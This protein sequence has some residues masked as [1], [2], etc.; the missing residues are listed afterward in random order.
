MND[1]LRGFIGYLGIVLMIAIFIMACDICI[2]S[3]DVHT[4]GVNS[5]SEHTFEI[6]TSSQYHHIPPSNKSLWTC[7]DH[8]MNHSLHNPSWGMVVI[9]SNRLFRGENHVVNYQINYSDN[10]LLI[11]DGL[12]ENDYIISGWE[13]DSCT[14]DYYHFYIDSE[15]PTRYYNR[16]NQ[17]HIRPN[18][19]EVYRDWILTR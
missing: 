6:T 17:F 7:F 18:A 3:A 1:R 9:S 16:R 2:A 10:T 11:H 13:Y 15:R 19:E 4:T 8:S 14:H 5:A 12:L